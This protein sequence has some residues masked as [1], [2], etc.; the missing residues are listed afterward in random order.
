MV[1][2]ATK[3]KMW[4][5]L[6]LT[7]R[8]GIE[9]L[10]DFLEHESDFFTAPCSTKFHL[11]KPSGLFEHTMNVVKCALEIN[12]KYG[13]LYP[14]ASI[15]IAA[16]GHDL[17]KANFYRELHEDPTDAQMR[18]LTSILAKKKI[19]VPQRLNKSYVGLLIDFM[20]K[21]W[22]PGVELPPFSLN[23]IVEDQ[24]PLGHG[25]KSLYIMQQFIKL[26]TDEALAIRWHM[27]TFDAGIHFPYPSGFAFNEAQKKSK[28]VTIII[29]ADI[30]ASNLMEV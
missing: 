10:Q 25:E 30:E 1:E 14:L 27:A 17:C 9:K 29:L 5:L 12:E 23:Y 20:L 28:L 24:L 22:E 15:I 26:T 8:E 19:P 11:A 13:A 18:Y 2:N 4:E 16:V 21:K 6:R 7:E 3:E